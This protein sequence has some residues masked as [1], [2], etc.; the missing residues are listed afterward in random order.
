MVS[1]ELSEEPSNP[2]GRGLTLYSLETSLTCKHN[3]AKIHGRL[4]EYKNCNTNTYAKQ[5]I[6]HLHFTTM[7]HN[8]KALILVEI[9]KDQE[10]SING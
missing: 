1:G 9:F 2:V 4:Q 5:S 10:C 8:F 6:V 7:V 3:A